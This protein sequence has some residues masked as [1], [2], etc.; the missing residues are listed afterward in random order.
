MKKTNK[1]NGFKHKAKK[2]VLKE[3][4]AGDMSLDRKNNKRVAPIRVLFCEENK[5]N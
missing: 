2:S 1:S 3:I 5:Q 4:Y